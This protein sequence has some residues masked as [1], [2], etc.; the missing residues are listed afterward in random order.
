MALSP[1][2]V[3]PDLCAAVLLVSHATDHGLQSSFEKGGAFKMKITQIMPVLPL[4]L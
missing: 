1:T 2:P 4:T 3:R